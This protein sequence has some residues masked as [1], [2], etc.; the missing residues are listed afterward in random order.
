MKNYFLSASLLLVLLCFSGCGGEQKPADLPPLHPVVVTVIQDGM[1][2]EGA[3]VLLMPEGTS[4]RFSSGGVTD[5]NG[6][7]TI[8]T[9]AK[10]PG[11]PEGRYKVT[12]K[13]TVEP[14]TAPVDNSLSYEEQQA[15]AADISKQTKSVVDSKFLKFGSTPFSIAVTSSGVT[16]TLDVGAAVDDLWDKVLGGSSSSGR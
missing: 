16:E 8:K 1:P 11:A 15:K 4:T 10:Y 12:I 7:A 13:K 2:L 5:K 6:V 14:S 9:D 3:T